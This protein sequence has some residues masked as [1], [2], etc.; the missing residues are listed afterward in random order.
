MVTPLTSQPALSALAAGSGAATHRFDDA[1]DRLAADGPDAEGM[2]GVLV[3]RGD[4]HAC[5]AG[6][7]LVSDTTAP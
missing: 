7:R 4:V 3:V 1:A 6:F 5:A 2:V